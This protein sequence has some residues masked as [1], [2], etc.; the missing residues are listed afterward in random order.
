MGAAPCSRGQLYHTRPLQPLAI[1]VP[2]AAGSCAVVL[3][4]IHGTS[5]VYRRFNELNHSYF[6]VY[7]YAVESGLHEWLLQSRHRQAMQ[8]EPGMCFCFHF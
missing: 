8:L 4:R 5:C 6:N 1:I 2:H 3:C 7:T